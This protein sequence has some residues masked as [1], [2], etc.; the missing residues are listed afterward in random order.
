MFC[1]TI[2]FGLVLS[3]FVRPFRITHLY[4]CFGFS[5]LNSY[6]SMF[7][8]DTFYIV[9]V[10]RILDCDCIFPFKQQHKVTDV[11]SFFFLSILFFLYTHLKT[12]NEWTVLL[13]M[14][15]YCLSLVLFWGTFLK[16][17]W[18]CSCLFMW[19]F[20]RFIECIFLSSKVWV[21]AFFRLTNSQN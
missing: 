12:R 1:I 18:F 20:N 4:F 13:F 16:I 10:I 9:V 2:Q 14:N 8:A 3:F 5:S 15:V 19:Y 17:I 21:V 6:H 7:L 11:G